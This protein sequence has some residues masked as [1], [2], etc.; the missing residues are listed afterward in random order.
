MHLCHTAYELNWGEILDSCVMFFTGIHNT[1]TAQN[2]F[3]NLGS[4]LPKFAYFLGYP[5]GVFSPEATV[6]N[7]PYAH[8]VTKFL[9][10]FK[11]P[12]CRVSTTEILQ[13]TAKKA[14]ALPSRKRHPFSR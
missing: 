12:D 11:M 5:E 9:N 4:E 6:T 10:M 14:D 1:K 7:N 3:S 2:F 13:K 8:Q